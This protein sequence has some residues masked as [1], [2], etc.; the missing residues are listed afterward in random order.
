M[1][2]DRWEL[3][4]VDELYAAAP[5]TEHGFLV[6]EGDIDGHLEYI[7]DAGDVDEG[8]GQD[9]LH[10]HPAVFERETCGP[11]ESGLWTHVLLISY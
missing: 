1:E 4:Y 7:E 11:V 5:E 8:T 3:E 10:D 2:F 9:Y 6:R